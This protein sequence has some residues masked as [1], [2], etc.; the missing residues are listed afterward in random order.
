MLEGLALIP[1]DIDRV[2]TAVVKMDYVFIQSD[3]DYFA[4]GQFER[5]QPLFQQLVKGL[6]GLYL[7]I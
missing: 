5:Q 1:G 3:M 2:Q 6:L 7:L 4:G